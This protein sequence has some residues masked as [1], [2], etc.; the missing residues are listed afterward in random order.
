MFNSEAERQAAAPA[1]SSFLRGSEQRLSGAQRGWPEILNPI[2]LKK[3]WKQVISNHRVV[4][5]PMNSSMISD[6]CII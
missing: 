3:C 2:H 6:V 1:V 5:I 4:S